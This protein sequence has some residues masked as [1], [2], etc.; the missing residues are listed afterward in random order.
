M[1]GIE[2]NFK[3]ANNNLKKRRQCNHE[4]RA[5]YYEK[6]KTKTKPKQIKMGLPVL[7]KMA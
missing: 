7:D 5:L 4:M 3:R 2:E 1:W 6:M